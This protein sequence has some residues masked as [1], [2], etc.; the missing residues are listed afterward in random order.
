M[1]EEFDKEAERERLRE[2]YE[3]ESSDRE[4]TERMSQLLLQG[5]T[6][7]NTH[8]DTCGSPIFRYQGQEF[9]PTCQAEE[10]AAEA[11]QAQSAAAEQDQQQ[12]AES[13]Q[14]APNAEQPTPERD[15]GTRADPAGGPPQPGAGNEAVQAGTQSASVGAASTGTAELGGAPATGQ[16]GPD[17]AAS[18]SR[19]IAALSDRAR[20]AD[21][22]RQAKALLEA[23]HEAAET[24]A[25]LAE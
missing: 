7:T 6:M 19:T 24:L 23:A 14:Q 25:T 5:A 15:Q 22:P 3:S 1:S 18:L 13:T 11:Q 20:E 17:V 12:P 2:K 8:C 4:I 16:G 10:T 9:C 21:D